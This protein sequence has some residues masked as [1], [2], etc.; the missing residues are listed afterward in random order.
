M[1][2]DEIERNDGQLLDNIEELEVEDKSGQHGILGVF[3]G[4]FKNFRNI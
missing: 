3:L 4:A 1:C 2:S